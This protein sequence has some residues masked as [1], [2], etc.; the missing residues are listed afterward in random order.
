MKKHSVLLKEELCEGCTNCVK[1][2]PTKAIRVHHGKA[3]IKGELCIDCAECIRTC[4]YH[5]KYSMTDSFADLEDY[6]YPLVLIPPSFYSQFR[7]VS[8]L[9]VKNSLFKLGFKEVLDV[10]LAA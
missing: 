2:C 8:P 6:A 7:K 1:N 10:S 4:A 5:A 9:E 3:I